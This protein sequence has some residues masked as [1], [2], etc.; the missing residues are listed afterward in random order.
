MREIDIMYA[1]D[2]ELVSIYGALQM[3]FTYLLRVTLLER[4]VAE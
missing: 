2:S 4:L 3:L 1:Y